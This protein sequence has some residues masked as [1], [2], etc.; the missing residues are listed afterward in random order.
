MN[1]FAKFS[2]LTVVL[3]VLT[4]SCCYYDP[5]FDTDDDMGIRKDFLVDKIY[6]YHG[7]LL[8]EYTYDNSNRLI[9]KAVADALVEP[10]RIIYRKW[11]DEFVYQNGHVS[12]IINTTNIR[13]D[14]GYVQFDYKTINSFE[15]DAYGRLIKKNGEALNFRY[16]NGRIVGSLHENDQ[17][18]K[19]D[20]LV[21]DNS[22][23]IIE[24]IRIVPELTA[25]GE[26]IPGTAVRT[27][28]YYE[29]DDKP[30]PNFGLDYLFVYNPFPYTEVPD[31]IMA[32]SK[33]N[34]TK[35]TEDGYAFIYTYNEDG[36][37]E[38][39]ETKWLDIETLE[40]MLLRISYKKTE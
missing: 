35:A 11:A 17:W 38:T 25:F 1:K 2:V 36:L 32:L 23:N 7:K 26:P 40:P 5:G 37:P 39:I 21:Y 28:R 9:K 6:N 27:V 3:S 22:G 31:L 4:I 13:E 12:K 33:N 15:Y 8:A 18:I 34:M 24:H 14:N 20:T 16:E 19:A 30:K 10:H 29:Y